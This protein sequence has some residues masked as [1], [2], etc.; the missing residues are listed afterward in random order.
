MSTWRSSEFLD[1]RV[2]ARRLPLS[3]IAELDGN[4][5]SRELGVAV[6]TS[7]PRVAFWLD[8]DFIVRLARILWESHGER[9]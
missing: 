3:E 7:T 9:R 8:F 1:R 5:S 2:A 6:G 4:P